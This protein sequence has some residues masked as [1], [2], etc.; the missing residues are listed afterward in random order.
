MAVMCLV[1]QTA[2]LCGIGAVLIFVPPI[3]ASLPTIF[4]APLAAFWLMAWY[5]DA[6][7]TAR[8]WRLVMAGREAN[9]LVVA[10]GRVAPHRSYLVFACHASFSIGVAAGLQALVTHF[11]DI[12]AMSCI[13]A[14]FGALHL[15]ALYHSRKFVKEMAD[16]WNENSAGHKAR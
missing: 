3:S 15:D 6:R 14:V 8:H 9:V 2:A 7:F 12:F 4:A 5:S 1:V 16:S 11:L 13:L 10:L